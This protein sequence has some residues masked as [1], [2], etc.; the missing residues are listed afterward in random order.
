MLR[1]VTH[2]FSDPIPALTE[3]NA[4]D[5]THVLRLIFARRRGRAK[6]IL[7]CLL[8]DRK[9]ETKDVLMFCVYLKMMNLVMDVRCY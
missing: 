3:L 6:E 1:T 2:P 4:N 8:N 7:Y 5:F 9:S